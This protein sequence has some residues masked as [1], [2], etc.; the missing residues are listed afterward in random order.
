MA[1]YSADQIVGKSLIAKVPIKIKRFAADN[2]PDVYTVPVGQTVGIVDSWVNPSETR[3][4]L[5]WSFL[6]SNGRAYYAAHKPGFYD[7]SALGQQGALTIK[8]QQEAAAAQNLTTGQII[9]KNFRLLVIVAGIAIVA[10]S[11]LPELIKRK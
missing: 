5:Y 4:T 8:E 10:K 11:V 2:S 1:I 6:D 9:E 7:V 3:A